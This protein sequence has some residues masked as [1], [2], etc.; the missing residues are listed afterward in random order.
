MTFDWNGD[1]FERDVEAAFLEACALL[2]FAFTRVIT[3]PGVFPEFPSADIVDTGRLRDAQLMTVESKISIR[4]DWNVDYALYVHEG[5]TR[6][7][8]TEVPGRPWTDKALELFDF[9]D[10]FIRLFNAKGSGVAVAAR[11]E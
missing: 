9:E 1:E 10:A 4:F 7:D 6:T 8:R 11:L 3:S 2:G 5:F